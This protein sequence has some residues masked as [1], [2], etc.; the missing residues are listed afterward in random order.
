MGTHNIS[1]FGEKLWKLYISLRPGIW[2][3]ELY[4]AQADIDICSFVFGIKQIFTYSKCPK[5]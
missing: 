5:M 1:V 3:Y 2:S 4:R